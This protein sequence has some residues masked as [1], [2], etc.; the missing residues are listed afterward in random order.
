MP[1]T[2][3]GDPVNDKFYPRIS[4]ALSSSDYDARSFQ[5]PY[6]DCEIAD[7]EYECDIEHCKM[8]H[9]DS[10]TKQDKE[11]KITEGTCTLTIKCVRNI[12][13]LRTIWI[14]KKVIRIFSKFLNEVFVY[15]KQLITLIIL[16]STILKKQLIDEKQ[17]NIVKVCI[18]IHKSQMIYKKT[19]V[20]NLPFDMSW[21][22]QVGKL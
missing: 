12:L 21:N 7:N 10:S 9:R 2:Y 18:C 4:C 3:I 14:I 13:Q 15:T 16:K 11:A 19:I 8:E 5:C 20:D 1:S 6:Y 22:H 17:S